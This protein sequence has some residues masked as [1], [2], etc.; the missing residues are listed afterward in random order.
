MTLLAHPL[1]L[2]VAALLCAAA[3][4]RARRPEPAARHA[5]AVPAP[6]R[7]AAL[8]PCPA[9]LAGLATRDGDEGR[10]T[11][12]GLVGVLSPER[13][14]RA[15][16][17]AA[18]A[19][20]ALALP[21]AALAPAGALL[22]P[23]LGLAGALLPS[24]WLACREAARRRALVRELP[25]LLDVLGICVE[26]GM[27]L[28]PA[29]GLAAGR[30]GGT[31]GAELEEVLRDLSLGTHRADA[32]RALVARTGAPELAQTVA[33]LL[34]AEELG[35][36]LSRALE[37]QAEALRL[38]RRQASRERAARAAPKIQL[39]VALVMVPAVLLLVLGVLLIELSRQVGG[40]VGAG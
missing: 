21:L 38:A 40:V 25:D 11:R 23:A 13:L 31:L 2:A 26:A 18:L 32:Y 8:V 39:V 19:A 3:A 34:Q 37:G 1:T 7:L 27:A 10:I 30:L 6:L 5:G 16:A 36:P 4:L 9:V 15:R 28:D 29:L 12:A 24:R 17:G 20:A 35:A 33:A 22:A 14:G